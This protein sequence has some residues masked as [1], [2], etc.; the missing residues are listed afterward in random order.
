MDLETK[1]ENREGGE[2]TK[3]F[4]EGNKERLL[5]FF[6]CVPRLTFGIR[7]VH[8]CAGGEQGFEYDPVSGFSVG[9]AACRL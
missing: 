8:I 9:L 3:R 1:R 5:F 7:H 4:L 2:E 6:L